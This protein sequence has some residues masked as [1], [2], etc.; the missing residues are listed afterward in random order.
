MKRA[1][2]LLI[3][4]LLCA[5]ASAT[6]ASQPQSSDRDHPTPVQANEIFGDLDNSGDEYFYSFAAGAGELTLTVD[7]KSSTG[8]ALLTFEL[9]DGKADNAIICCEYAQADGDGQSGRDI[10]SVKFAKG[11]MTVLHLTIGKTGR[12]TYRVRFSGTAVPK[13]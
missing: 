5:A 12:G 13:G 2:S 7:V 1:I 3:A 11:Q 4:F 8:Q 9:L 10:K 6:G